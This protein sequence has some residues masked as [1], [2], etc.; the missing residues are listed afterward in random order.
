MNS[1]D[2]FISREKFQ[3]KKRKKYSS[4]KKKVGD[5]FQKNFFRPV[6]AQNRLLKHTWAFSAQQ[7]HRNK[8]E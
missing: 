7:P 1:I 2:R 4:L 6:L 5:G 3:S 8:G